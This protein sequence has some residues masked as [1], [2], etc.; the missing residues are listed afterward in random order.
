MYSPV[1]SVIVPVFNVMMCFLSLCIFRWRSGF[2]GLV[3]YD[4][5]IEVEL[6]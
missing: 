6:A 2:S 3:M 1:V 4:E 5:D